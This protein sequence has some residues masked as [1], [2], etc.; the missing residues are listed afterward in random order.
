MRISEAAKMTG[1]S[2]S[3]IRFYEKKGLLA[4]VREEESKYRDYSD[5]DIRQLKQIILYRK[6]NLPVETIY[7]LQKGEASLEGVLKR[8][9]EE[10]IA[11]REM[12]EGAIELCRKI[13]AA[14][15]LQTLDVDYYLNY[16]YEEEESGKRFGQIDELLEDWA[17]FSKLSAGMYPLMRSRRF[18]SF[19]V[20]R[21][22][23]RGISLAVL[24]LYVMLPAVVLWEQYERDGTITS[25]SIIFWT[26]W[27]LLLL[28]AFLHFRNLQRKGREEGADS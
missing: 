15:D 6:M 26:G 28:C 21:R 22:V 8:Q 27:L 16:V 7:L 1:L 9:E 13:R 25:G 2:V 18:G 17:D 20:N 4:P 10:L 23:L 5:E 14:G 11:Q 19:V 12:L 3:N 24:L